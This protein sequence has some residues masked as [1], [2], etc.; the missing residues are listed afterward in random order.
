M[1]ASLSVPFASA[2]LQC[3]KASDKEGTF[4]EQGPKGPCLH[5]RPRI[6]I[7]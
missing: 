7:S 3:I 6:E 4:L 2:A 5:M 1:F